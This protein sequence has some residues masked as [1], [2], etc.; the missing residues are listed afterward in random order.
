MS[1][2]EV[3]ARSS[4]AQFGEEAESRFAA[5]R[6]AYRELIDEYE[7]RHPSELSA[8]EN[9]YL[10]HAYLYEADCYFE[11]RLYQEALSRYDRSAALLR[12]S[13]SALAAYV[14]I[15]NC[16][17]FLGQAAEAKAALARAQVLIEGMSP[18]IFAS[19][20]SPESKE[21]WKEYFAW[22]E[23]AEIF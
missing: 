12:D 14:Q 8:L 16:H 15:I 21:E 6:H 11:A 17:V 7:L 9:V 5:A 20:V 3:R 23:R 10:R 22:L 19:S 2:R 18:E 1:D 13:P 4:A